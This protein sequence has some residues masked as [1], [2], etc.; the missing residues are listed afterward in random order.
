MFNDEIN[1]ERKFPPWDML[2]FSFL[3]TKSHY[4][5]INIALR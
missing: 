4:L 5:K 1:Y 3:I 2:T